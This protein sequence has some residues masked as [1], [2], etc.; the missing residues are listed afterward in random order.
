MK[1]EILKEDNNITAIV[2]GRLDTLS[3]PQFE[4][5]IRPLHEGASS[6]VT[7]DCKGLEYI[8]SSGLRVFLALLKDVKAKGGSLTLRH[9]NDEIANIFKI[10]GFAKLFTIKD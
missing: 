10:T 6:D 5:D 1:T 9:V 2:S 7:L 8:S 4:A 3:A